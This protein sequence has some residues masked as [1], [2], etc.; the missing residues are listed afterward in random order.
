MTSMSGCAASSVAKPGAKQIVVIDDQ[1]PHG[2]SEL[3]LAIACSRPHLNAPHDVDVTALRG[4]CIGRRV[5]PH[6]RR[7]GD[8]SYSASE[9]QLT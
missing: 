6:E 8:T 3:A 4:K 7:M 9:R 1:N 5:Q 2:L